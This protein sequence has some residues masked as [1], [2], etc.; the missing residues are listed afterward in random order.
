MF[1]AADELGIMPEVVYHS[2]DTGDVV[3][4]FKF[5]MDGE[6]A[7]TGDGASGNRRRSMRVRCVEDGREW[8]SQKE[9]AKALFISQSAISVSVRTGKP[10]AGMHFERA[11]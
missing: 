1:K 11:D 9:A 8:P 2:L 10:V 5:V 7:R 3:A 6:R 4:G